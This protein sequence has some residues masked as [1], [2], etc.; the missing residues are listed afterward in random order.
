MSANR[1]YWLVKSEP[2][3]WSWDQMVAAAPKEQAGPACAT[4]SPSNK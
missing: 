1:G 3:A 2:D 4:T